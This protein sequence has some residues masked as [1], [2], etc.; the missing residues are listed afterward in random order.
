MTATAS[1]ESSVSATPEPVSLPRRIW[2][3]I[4]GAGAA[5]LALV[6]HVLHHAGP[7][8]GAALLA[9][10]TGS[11]LF[12]ALGF[13]ASV[14]FLLKLHRKTGSW[15]LPAAAL[16]AFAAAFVL[17]T[18]LIAPAITGSDDNADNSQP[19]TPAVN[20]EAHH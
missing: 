1:V 3:L 8:A 9:G 14:P 10:T 20:H 5:V 17:S 16:A 15:R 2:V 6:P 11:L 12:G 7:L 13:I 4:S 18:L 19:N